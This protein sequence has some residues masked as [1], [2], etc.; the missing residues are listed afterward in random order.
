M[1][2]SVVDKPEAPGQPQIWKTDAH[3]ADLSW[4]AP[5]KD[6]GAP[7]TH[8]V[9]EYN[10][11]GHAKWEVY[12]CVDCIDISHKILVFEILTHNKI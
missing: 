6:G 9:V 12:D 5:V 2:D 11:K 8:Y 3:S 1:F 10:R 4:S 7:I